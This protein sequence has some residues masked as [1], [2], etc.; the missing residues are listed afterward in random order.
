LKKLIYFDTSALI[1]EFAP[2]EVGYDLIDKITTAA[3]QDSSRMQI[4]SSVWAINEAVAVID[5]KNRN[6]EITPVEMQTVIAALSQRIKDSSENTSFRFAPVE[7]GMIAKSRLLIAQ[8]HISADD[9]LHL[10][11]GWLYDCDY[12]LFH[13]KKIM[14]IKPLISQASNGNVNL[15]DLGDVADRK[16]VESQLSL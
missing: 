11:T 8:Y 12:L 4:V 1:K 14:R 2:K 9:A 6:K 15:I 7:H 16:R 10:Y 5:R 13:D 3:R